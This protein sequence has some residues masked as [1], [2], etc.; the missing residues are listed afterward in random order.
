[1]SPMCGVQSDLKACFRLT[2]QGGGQ[3]GS[4]ADPYP[5]APE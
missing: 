1:M 3:M 2:Q 5:K 4:R